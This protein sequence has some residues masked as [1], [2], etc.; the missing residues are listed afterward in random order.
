[1]HFV[2]AE[3]EASLVLITREGRLAFEL[4]RGVR[5]IG[6]HEHHYLE[7]RCAGA[8]VT[9]IN[10]SSPVGL[11]TALPTSAECSGGSSY[12]A[13]DLSYAADAILAANSAPR[14]DDMSGAVIDII[15][16]I[17]EFYGYRAQE[18]A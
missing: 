18:E 11:N 7:F 15:K 3:V 12:D 13:A 8:P 5:K 10:L 6:R 4:V 17:L 2:R 1:M 9:T 16:R 14:A